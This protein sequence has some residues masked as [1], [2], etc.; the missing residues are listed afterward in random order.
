MVLIDAP[1]VGVRFRNDDE[2]VRTPELGM[3]SLPPGSDPAAM[4]YFMSGRGDRVFFADGG[5][6][7]GSDAATPT[8]ILL[9]AKGFQINVFR[10]HLSDLYAYGCVQ[11][12]SIRSDYGR[13]HSLIGR[14]ATGTNLEV[15]AAS[16]VGVKNNEFYGIDMS[17]A[18]VDVRVYG[19]VNNLPSNTKFFG[20][21]AGSIT[22]VENVLRTSLIGTEYT[23]LTD[24]GTDTLVVRSGV[25]RPLKAGRISSG[26]DQF[27]HIT[28]DDAANNITGVS[29]SGLP[30]P[31][32][33]Q[34]DANSSDV[35]INVAAVTGRVILQHQGT[36]ILIVN[37]PGDIRMIGLPT[38][39][40][41]I[42]NRLWRDPSAGNV[43][44]IVP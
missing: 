2:T 33:V 38:S 40:P 15:F 35:R 24:S 36:D 18:P 16:G 44:K 32:V 14:R 4:R 28:G 42:S 20:G 43:V 34:A 25:V 3:G 21:S 37:G 9:E 22:I 27:V 31:L 10:P 5:T 8:P 29:P 13:Y 17:E 19:A 39:A 41:A 7:S 6:L 30:K 12:Y 23:T 11:N 26:N 1:V